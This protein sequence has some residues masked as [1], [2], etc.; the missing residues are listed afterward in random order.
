M[1]D[2]IRLALEPLQEKKVKASSSKN[3]KPVVRTKK[4]TKLKKA[5][6]KK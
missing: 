3:K 5:S 2:V 6:I 4:K 1:L